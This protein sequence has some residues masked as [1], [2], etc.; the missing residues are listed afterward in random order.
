MVFLISLLRHLIL[1]FDRLISFRVIIFI[2]FE[3][4]GSIAKDS[5]HIVM[6]TRC[7]YPL[8]NML[9]FILTSMVICFGFLIFYEKVRSAIELKIP[10]GNNYNR[11][12]P[13][14]IVNRS[15]L[16]PPM[17]T[18]EYRES[19]E[20]YNNIIDSGDIILSSSSNKNI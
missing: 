4:S 6:R 7:K 5:V 14:L 2:A 13:L 9:Y 16:Y 8:F 15:A 17:I 20:F 12:Y 3:N 11:L 10:F 1:L 18:I 19:F